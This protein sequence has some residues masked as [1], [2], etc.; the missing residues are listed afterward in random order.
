M[1]KLADGTVNF[2]FRRSR[3]IGEMAFSLFFMA[4]LI[5]AA[6]K[7]GSGANVAPE[8][9]VSIALFI[10]FVDR[11]TRF[12]DKEPY[13]HLCPEGVQIKGMPFLNWKDVTKTELK[14]GHAVD[15]PLAPEASIVFSVKDENPE[16]LQGRAFVLGSSFY[17]SLDLLSKSDRKEFLE[18]TGKLTDVS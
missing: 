10:L 7:R 16:T 6:F 17:V 15:N 2:Y 9:V 18:E 12:M 13:V 5:F 1:K 14:M 8:I 4:V 11:V 3:L